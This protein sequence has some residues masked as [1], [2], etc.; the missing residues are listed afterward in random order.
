MRESK[1]E[2][3][4]EEEKKL[5]EENHNIVYAFLKYYGYSIEEYYNIAVFGY[6]KGVQTYYRQNEKGYDLFFICWQYLR[7]E[8]KNH[9][10]MENSMKRKPMEKI[11]S[12]DV[13]YSEMDNLY[14]IVKGKSLEDELTEKETVDEVLENLSE[15]QRKIAE[16]KMEG[17]K[18]K[19]IYGVLELSPATYFREVKKIKLK[20]SEK[21]SI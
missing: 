20:L 2:P 10:R 8:I 15:I 7:T 13:E 16:M 6:L 21:F 19:E 18:S 4:M 11:L 17:Y 9:F 3:L 12:L 14:N 1:L 5:A